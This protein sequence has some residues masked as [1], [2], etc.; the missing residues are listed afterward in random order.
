LEE[1]HSFLKKKKIKQTKPTNQKAQ[2]KHSKQKT[3]PQPHITQ[4]KASQKKK[5]KYFEDITLDF[6]YDFHEGQGEVLIH[7]FLQMLFC[8][9]HLPPLQQNFIKA[10]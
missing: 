1:F 2:K 8:V 10:Y 7:L 9:F 4:N 6:S 5:H 3:P